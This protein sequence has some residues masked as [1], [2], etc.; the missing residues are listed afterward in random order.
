MKMKNT[1]GEPAN[2]RTAKKLPNT[3]RVKLSKRFRHTR[4]FSYKRLILSLDRVV[5]RCDSRFILCG[6][7]AKW[8]KGL[9]HTLTPQQKRIWHSFVHLRIFHIL[10]GL[11]VWPELNSRLHLQKCDRCRFFFRPHFHF[12]ESEQQICS[13][14]LSLGF[15]F[16]IW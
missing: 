11:T 16:F 7:W 6:G 15:F 13:K 3:K 10:G 4:T 1:F 2:E 12:T 14:L 8:S 5:V 9:Q